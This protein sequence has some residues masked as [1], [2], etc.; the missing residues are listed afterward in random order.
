MPARIEQMAP[1]PCAR[2]LPQP[3]RICGLFRPN[4]SQK[5]RCENGFVLRKG[6]RMSNRTAAIACAVITGCVSIFGTSVSATAAPAAEPAAQD[7]CLSGPKGATPAG[8]HWYYRIEKGT[9]RK[10]W[11]LADEVGKTKQ[12]ATRA[13]TS[14]DTSEED[15]P[16]PAKITPAPKHETSKKPIQ[17]S[18]ANAR[19]ELTTGTDED[20]A[21]AETTWPPMTSPAA[22]ADIRADNQVAAIQPAPEAAPKQSWN[23]ATRWPETGC[24]GLRQRSARGCNTGARAA[25]SS[26]DCRTSRHGGCAD[27]GRAPGSSGDRDTCAATTGYAACR[28]RRPVAQGLAEHPRLRAGARRHRR[29]VAVQIFPGRSRARTIVL[30]ENAVVSGTPLFQTT[31]PGRMIQPGRTLHQLRH[32]GGMFLSPPRRNTIPCPN[33]AYST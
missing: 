1:C 15:T 14:S 5:T 18:V 33:R 16:P 3:V 9:K 20:P 13:P 32:R 19:A 22:K 11:Y 7:E 24:R 28:H 4:L 12:A 25:C 17:K 6:D 2:M 30:M 27:T 23:I 10:C 26:S 8:A 31:T 21:L 29:P